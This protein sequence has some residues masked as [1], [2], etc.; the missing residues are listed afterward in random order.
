VAV[1][2]PDDRKVILV[3]R[4]SRLE[5]LLVRFNTRDQARFYVEHLGADFG[6]YVEEHETY[7][8]S[9]RLVVR[10]LE[11]HGRFQQV[12]RAFV[13]NFVFARDDVVLAL[14]QDGLVA[15]TLKYLDGQPLVGINPD[16]ARWDGVLL[17][18][19]PASVVPLLPAVLAN[20]ARTRSVTMGEARLADGQRLFAVN[21]FFIGPKSHTSARYQIRLRGRSETQSSSGIIVS[22]G[23][24]STGWMRSVVTG[25]CAVASETTHH[26]IAWKFRPRAWDERRL[27][28]A[29]REPFPSRTSAASLICGSV[30]EETPL[31]VTSQMAENGVIFSDGIEGDFLSFNAGTTVE[32]RVAERRGTLIQ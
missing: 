13:P 5:D 19:Q 10:A 6:D 12:D 23:L 32:V 15:N 11:S 2:R 31:I 27:Y 30:S 29:V 20:Q 25:S 22:T 16:P 26:A 1:P 9:K 17:P 4:R 18:W 21:D 3:T 7:Q 24:G 8:E 14:G 28:F